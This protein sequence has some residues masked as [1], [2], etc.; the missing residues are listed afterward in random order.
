MATFTLLPRRWYALDYFY[1]Y[2]GERHAS[3]IWV[4][5]IIPHHSGSGKLSIKFWH[6]NCA[7]DM[8]DQDYTLR[9]L[10][11]TGGY[12]LAERV[13]GTEPPAVV[14]TEITPEWLKQSFPQLGTPRDGAEIQTWCDEH[15]RHVQP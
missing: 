13:C 10:R 11:R 1:P 14:L 15:I 7:E 5:E 4:S 12:L 3:P 8:H 9:V 2:S 6:A